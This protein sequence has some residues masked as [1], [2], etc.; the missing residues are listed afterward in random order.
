MFFKVGGGAGWLN[1][2]V[3]GGGGGGGGG[4]K[5]SGRGGSFS[6]GVGPKGS[7]AW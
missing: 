1:C 6:G 5:S 7:V 2:E 3:R 4:Y